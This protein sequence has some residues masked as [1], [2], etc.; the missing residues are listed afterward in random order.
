MRKIN[1]TESPAPHMIGINLFRKGEQDSNSL[2]VCFAIKKE[3]A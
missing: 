3:D 2:L 1:K